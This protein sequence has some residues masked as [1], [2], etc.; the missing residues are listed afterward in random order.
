MAGLTTVTFAVLV[1]CLH[2]FGA[3]S[4][5][6]ALLVV[7]LPMTWLGVASRLMQPRLPEGYHPCIGGSV[8]GACMKCSAS[9]CSSGCCAAARSRCSTRTCTSLPTRPPR[10]VAHLDQR[11]R[12]AEASHFILLVL[13]LGVVV[14]AVAR[15][16]WAAAGWTLL[17]D[18]GIRAIKARCQSQDRAAAEV[19]VRGSTRPTTRRPPRRRGGWG[20]ACRLR[21]GRSARPVRAVFAGRV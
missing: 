16:W 5:W 14:H 9:G 15:G 8:T 10:T 6:F 13:T 2:E 20:T 7:W 12:D 1:W 11:M 17:F 21:S 3:R 4:V 19:A 18:A